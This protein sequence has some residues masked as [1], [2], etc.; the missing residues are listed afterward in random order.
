MFLLLTYSKLVENASLLE[1]ILY[2]NQEASHH[3]MSLTDSRV[4]D[5]QLTFENF[6][7]HGL[8]EQPI[9]QKSFYR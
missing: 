4:I 1:L 6:F 7:A 2:I 5:L 9:S 3:L 8:N